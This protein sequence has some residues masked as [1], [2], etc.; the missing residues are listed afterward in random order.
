MLLCHP[1]S[2]VPAKPRGPAGAML[3]S[4]HPELRE[5]RID[6]SDCLT[7]Q[8]LLHTKN[9][10]QTPYLGGQGP[11]CAAP[12]SPLSAPLASIPLS[13]LP[14]ASGRFHL[15]VLCLDSSPRFSPCWLPV[16]HFCLKCQNDHPR[17]PQETHGDSCFFASSNAMG[18]TEKL[19]NPV[20]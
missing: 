9:H 5:A 8:G 19:L 10:M 12:P 16:C 2:C 20:E 3:A 18:T 15:A 17:V 6:K 14:P 11:T 4:L 7:S 13:T 1:L